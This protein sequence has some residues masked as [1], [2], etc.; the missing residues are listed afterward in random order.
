MSPKFRIVSD[1]IKHQVFFGDIDISNRVSSVEID[2]IEGRSPTKAY[3]EIIDADVE[4]VATCET[5]DVSIYGSVE[6]RPVHSV[7]IIIAADGTEHSGFKR[8]LLYQG[9]QVVYYEDGRAPAI[10]RE[11]T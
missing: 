11:L 9:E 4:L 10:I 2:R 6:K 8:P 5:M 1:G 3:I 7:D